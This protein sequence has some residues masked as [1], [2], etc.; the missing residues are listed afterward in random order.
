MKSTL[1]EANQVKSTKSNRLLK[2]GDIV[3]YWNGFAMIVS[4]TDQGVHPSLGKERV[5]LNFGDR[6]AMTAF[7][8]E[9]TTVLNIQ[10]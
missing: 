3:Q 8:D 2:V 6:P 9:F 4:I 7:L 5:T 1:K 10:Q